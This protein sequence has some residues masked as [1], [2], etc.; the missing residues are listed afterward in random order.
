MIFLM[1]LWITKKAIP[2]S[3]FKK[4]TI[5]S[6]ERIAINSIT[7]GFRLL[8]KIWILRDHET[9]TYSPLRWIGLGQNKP[10]EKMREGKAGCGRFYRPLFVSK[11]KRKEAAT[12]A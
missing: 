3:R 6:P 7:A 12:A 1:I 4:A 9:L 10:G 5:P 11:A 2:N 8:P